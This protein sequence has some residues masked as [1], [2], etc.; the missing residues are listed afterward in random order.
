MR[1]GWRC[2]PG[3]KPQFSHKCARRCIPSPAAPSPRPRFSPVLHEPAW[4]K[5]GYRKASEEFHETEEPPSPPAPDCFFHRS[6][7]SAET[8]RTVDIPDNPQ[9]PPH[10]QVHNRKQARRPDLRRC[11]SRFF[12]T[13]CPHPPSSCGPFRRPADRRLRPLAGTP[14]RPS[15]CVPPR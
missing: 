14:F 8:P 10:T 13:A 5:A 11:S 2:G 12:S 7:K 15:Q 1:K 9:T 3:L 6:C 4:R